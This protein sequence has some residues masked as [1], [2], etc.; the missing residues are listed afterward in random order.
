TA[1]PARPTR[2]PYATLFRSAAD[3]R[4]RREVRAEDATRRVPGSRRRRRGPAP[5]G[6][7]ARAHRGGTRPTPLGGPGFLADRQRPLALRSRSEEHTSELQS[8]E[9]LVCR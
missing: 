4:R 5:G 8:R 6:E 1:P 3:R 9:N 7:P 2:C